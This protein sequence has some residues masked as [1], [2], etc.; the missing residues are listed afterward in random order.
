MHWLF[1][2]RKYRNEVVE[3]A[4]GVLILAPEEAPFISASK[5]LDRTLRSNCALGLTVDR[6]ALSIVLSVHKA[7]I[8]RDMTPSDAYRVLV[9]LSEWQ[10]RTV[11]EQILFREAVIERRTGPDMLLTRF[12]WWSYYLTVSEGLGNITSEESASFANTVAALLAKKAAEGQ[13]A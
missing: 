2:W 5:S 10:H 12:L 7:T 8:V 13:S 1:K 3:R 11:R 4:L 6:S 9:A